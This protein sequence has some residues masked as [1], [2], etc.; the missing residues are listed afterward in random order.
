MVAK[1]RR[2][3]RP[4]GERRYKVLF[5]IATEGT[6]TEP[7]YFSLFESDSSIVRVCCLSGKRGSSP[8]TVLRRMRDRLGQERLRLLDEAWLVVDR[9][10]WTENQLN[11]LHQWSQSQENF[12]FA[13]SNPSFEYWLL[14]HFEDGT[15]I[16]SSRDCI[17]RLKRWLH[18][19]DKGFDTNKICRHQIQAAIARAKSRDRPRTTDWPRWPG[20]STVYRLVENIF[21]KEVL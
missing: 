4:L 13:L 2:F 5:L 12:G 19:Y 18:D 21:S 20:Q 15:D 6:K 1:R 7:L 17:D 10:R 11:Q 3:E 14:L 8:P 16:G 9:D